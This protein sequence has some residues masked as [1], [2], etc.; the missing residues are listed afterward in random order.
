MSEVGGML[1][2]SDALLVHLRKD[3]LFETTIPSKTQ[4]YMAIGKP[5]LMAVNGD[6]ALLVKK[7][8]CGVI[9]E[10]ESAE[11]IAAAALHALWF[12]R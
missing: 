3:P 11:A 2:E 7:A 10:S 1:E 6:A 8:G 12:V 5:I 4:A 9:A